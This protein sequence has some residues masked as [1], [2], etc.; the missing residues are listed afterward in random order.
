MTAEQH[1]NELMRVAA[2]LATE[3]I[4]GWANPFVVSLVNA[5]SFLRDEPAPVDTGD[6]VLSQEWRPE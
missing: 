1:A 6:A 5:A 4:Q 3:R 2:Q